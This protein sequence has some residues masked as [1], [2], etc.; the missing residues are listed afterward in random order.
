MSKKKEGGWRKLDCTV[1]QRMRGFSHSERITLLY[2]NS[3]PS[4]HS[5]GLYYIPPPI[6]SF[7]TG[8]DIVDVDSTLDSLTVRGFILF[9]PSSCV[10]FVPGLLSA[11]YGSEKLNADQTKGLESYLSK[12]IHNPAIEAFVQHF[13]KENE[14]NYTP[15][16]TPVNTPLY[17][18]EGRGGYTGDWTGDDRDPFDCGDNVSPF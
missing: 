18:G 10:V 7:E 2:L 17:T 11:T 12:L 9:D 6:I 3:C 15:L 14:L 1:W 4:S 13:R 8:L 16:Y 5:S